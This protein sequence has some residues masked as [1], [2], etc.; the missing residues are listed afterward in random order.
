MR[1][2]VEPCFAGNNNFEWRVTD[3]RTGRRFHIRSLTEGIWSRSESTR[4]RDRAA[5]EFEIR[6]DRIRIL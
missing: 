4:I 1:I 2:K 3:I 5:I 6:R